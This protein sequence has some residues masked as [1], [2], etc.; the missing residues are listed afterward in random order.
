MPQTLFQN[1]WRSH[2]VRG[3]D[4]GTDLLFI[5]RIFLH[6]RTG[7]IALTSLADSGRS[8]RHPQHVFCTMDHI[9]DTVP[10]RGDETMMPGGRAFIETTRAAAQAAGITL[11][12][13]TDP[14][15]GISHVV[16]AEQ[17]IALPG[18]TTVC[19]DS[20]TCT[21][22][23]LG[24]LAFG[25]GSSDCE[26]AMATSTLRLNPPKQMR[27]EVSGQLG[28]GV[29]AKDLVL[30]LIGR[31]GAAGAERHA[32]EFTGPAI[33]ALPL[34]GRFTLCNMAVEFSAFTGIIAPDETTLA[35]PAGRPY[36]PAGAARDAALAA[37]RQ[38]A[39]DDDA[40]FDKEITIA[41]AD[42]APTVTWGT[43]PQHA[44]PITGT[45]PDPAG[46]ADATTRGGM[47]RAL[48]YMDLAPGTA[49]TGLPIN[50][51]FIGS[52]TNS[53]IEDLREAARLLDGRRVA[54][55]IRAVCVPGSSAVKAQA[56]REGLHEVLQRAGF[57]WRE[58]GCS[59]CFYAGGE[60]F[61]PGERVITTT[62]RN[63][64][65]RQGRGVR[66]HLASPATVA[67]SAI[68]GAI[69]DPRQLADQGR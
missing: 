48:E 35:W 60:G 45:V 40:E 37:W 51:A 12:D 53:R 61:A 67:A 43:S 32:V 15:Q 11:F 38:L 13:I 7:S 27:I 58:S 26:H 49:L 63:F 21:L 25:I 18:L 68:A 23:A 22:G 31:Y 57:E 20:H 3:F 59:M 42:V 39:S 36:A 47:Q 10:G 2:R 5:D 14:R 9:V 33:A 29:Y 50:A 52:C 24:T 54:P 46:A 44:A 34:A 1:I 66:S 41:A 62:N 17:G 16:S 6:E 28:T 64:E 69:A 4:D 55:G 8:V 65:G 19:P 30:H 56:E